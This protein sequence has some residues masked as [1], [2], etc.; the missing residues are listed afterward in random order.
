MEYEAFTSLAP[1]EEKQFVVFEEHMRTTSSFANKAGFIAAGAI[2]GVM[3]L[4]VLAFWAPL[5]P[6]GGEE[7]AAAEKPAAAEKT[8]KKEAPAPAPTPAPTPAPAEAPK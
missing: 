8:D 6:Y 4:I 3:I 1:A 7:E 5:K 2:G